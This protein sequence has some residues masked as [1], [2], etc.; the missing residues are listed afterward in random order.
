MIIVVAKDVRVQCW[1]RRCAKGAAAFALAD[2]GVDPIF[3]KKLHGQLPKRRIKRLERFKD[4]FS[5]LGKTKRT[6]FF[7]ERGVLIVKRD[8]RKPE[9]LSLETKAI[10]SQAIVLLRHFHHD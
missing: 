3:G 10:L 1:R 2:L 7:A 9:K 5:C 8:A 4:E 6:R